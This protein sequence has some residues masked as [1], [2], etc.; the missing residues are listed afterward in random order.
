ML[1]LTSSLSASGILPGHGTYTMRLCCSHKG[2]GKCHPRCRHK[3]VC[4][5]QLHENLVIISMIY[6]SVPA[7]RTCLMHSRLKSSCSVARD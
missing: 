3:L 7:L 6:G 4:T 1:R 2:R 5:V